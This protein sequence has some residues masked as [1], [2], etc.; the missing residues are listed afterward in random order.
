MPTRG[1]HSAFIAKE[2]F[3]F[4]LKITEKTT[5]AICTTDEVIATQR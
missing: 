3:S 1:E 5:D 4:S 2:M